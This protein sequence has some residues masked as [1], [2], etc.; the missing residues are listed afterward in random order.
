MPYFLC[1]KSNRAVSTVFIGLSKCSYA[2][3]EQLLNGFR[4]IKNESVSV[5]EFQ[6]FGNHYKT[7]KVYG[8]LE[9]LREDIVRR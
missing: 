9:K 5:R 6:S 4:G 3:F 2:I 1:I 8:K 7:S